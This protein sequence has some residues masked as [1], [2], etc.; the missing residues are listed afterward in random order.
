[1]LNLGLEYLV[2]AQLQQLFNGCITIFKKAEHLFNLK[3]TQAFKFALLETLE[4]LAK[5]QSAILV[6][7]DKVYE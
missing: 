6:W 4:Q 3:Q 7:S 2:N 5:K 1:M